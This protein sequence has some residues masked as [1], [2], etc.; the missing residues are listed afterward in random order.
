MSFSSKLTILHFSSSK[1]K[2]GGLY[3]DTQGPTR[4]CALLTAGLHFLSL[5]PSLSL[6]RPPCPPPQPRIFA[7]AGASAWHLPSHTWL[8]PS[9]PSPTSVPIT[10]NLAPHPL[11]NPRPSL[12]APMKSR[13]P[14][15]VSWSPH[16]EELLLL[17]KA[18]GCCVRASP[19]P[20]LCRVSLSSPVFRWGDFRGL[21]S[22]V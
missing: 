6:L 4:P 16:L 14:R 19:T 3:G 17:S 13:L 9:P 11:R 1:K 18:T 21:F 10:L 12:K 8:A 7:R 22:C 2:K 20:S 5:S 15:K